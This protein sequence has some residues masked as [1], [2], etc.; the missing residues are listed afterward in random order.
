V[1]IAPAEF[2]AGAQALAT[3]RQSKGYKTLVV[4]IEDIYDE[5][6]FGLRSPEAIK[7][8]LATAYNTWQLKPAYVVLAGEGSFDYKDNKGYHDSVIPTLM[9]LTPYGLDPSD[10]SLGDVVGNDGLPE[11]SIGRLP[12]LT[13]LELGTLVAKIKTY[14]ASSG[15]WT[16]RALMLAD[17]PDRA[18]DF[19]ADSE[20]MIGLLSVAYA[21][22]RQYQGSASYPTSKQAI[23]DGF[24]GGVGWFNYIG[25]GSP[26]Q[27]MDE[28][29]LTNADV[30]KLNNA[31]ALPVMTAMT[32]LVGDYGTPGVDSLSESLL[33]RAGGG[34]VAN[35]AP[36]GL[37]VN[38][39]SMM[40]D[41]GFF[42]ATFQTGQKVLGDA[43]RSA[44]G[45]YVAGGGARYT[46]ETYN[47]LG[48][49]ALRVK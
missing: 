6:N 41:E 7:S 8:F 26:G 13:S 31:T 39:L 15:S 18:G 48:D 29:L 20:E 3:Y 37:S 34:T 1:V 36:T 49:P 5:F 27:L 14:E 11:I 38:P 21:P 19:H 2:T 28:A 35:W 25:H 12:A 32:C 44:Q 45:S 10:T 33:L 40:L 42:R 47:L 30:V 46:L 24:N 16:S 4:D 23:I 43:I 9:V 22:V 17:N